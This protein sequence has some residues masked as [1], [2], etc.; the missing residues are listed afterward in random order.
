MRLQ[1]KDNKKSQTRFLIG[2][3]FL[4]SLV[5]LA[6]LGIFSLLKNLDIRKFNPRWERV[7]PLPATSPE[8]RL[9]DLLS[10]KGFPIDFPLVSTTSGILAK[11]AGGT[12][13]LF[14]KD[15]EFDVQVDALQ[16]ILSRLKIEGKQVSSID[17]R[18]DRPIVIY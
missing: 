5:L 13:I 9:T 3:I 7:S 2:I 16:I 14:S 1:E 11:T 6:S 18:F 17:L 10:E 4:L 8:R 12:R 15:K